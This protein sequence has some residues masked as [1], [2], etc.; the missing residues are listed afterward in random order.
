MEVATAFNDWTRGDAG[1]GTL[2]GKLFSLSDKRRYYPSA[3]EASL[4][5]AGSHGDD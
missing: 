3:A 1:F 4:D 2:V 5:A